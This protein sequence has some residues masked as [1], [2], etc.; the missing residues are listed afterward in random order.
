MLRTSS[1]G[2]QCLEKAYFLHEKGIG[3]EV[4]F[5]YVSLAQSIEE[6]VGKTFNN[7]VVTVEKEL[8]KYLEVPLM[9]KSR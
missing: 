2:I 9:V 1:Q 6:F 4:H 3:E 7:W 8:T 5:Q